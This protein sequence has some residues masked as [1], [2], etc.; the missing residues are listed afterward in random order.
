MQN[1]WGSQDR[2]AGLINQSPPNAVPL[3]DVPL[4]SCLV[5]VNS[6]SSWKGTDSVRSSLVCREM[7]LIS[8]VWLHPFLLFSSLLLVLLSPCSSR[9]SHLWTALPHTV[10]LLFWRMPGYSQGNEQSSSPSSRGLPDPVLL[11]LEEHDMFHTEV[12]TKK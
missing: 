6:E 4:L 11:V 3:E 5:S 1:D 12:Q 7:L 2:K 10:Y 8:G 9:K